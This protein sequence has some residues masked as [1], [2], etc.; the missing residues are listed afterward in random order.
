MPTMLVGNK[1]DQQEENRKVDK[2]LVVACAEEY[3]IPFLTTS[4][5]AG[6]GILFCFHALIRSVSM[7]C[8]PVATSFYANDINH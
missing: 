5:K 3:S 6:M 8:T 7:Q 4:A 2:H 1:C